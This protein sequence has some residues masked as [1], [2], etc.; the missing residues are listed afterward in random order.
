MPA[1]GSMVSGD[2]EVNKEEEKFI[3][4]TAH[5]FFFFTST[6]QLQNAQTSRSSLT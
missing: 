3:S 6:V 5:A 4:V 1:D 2:E